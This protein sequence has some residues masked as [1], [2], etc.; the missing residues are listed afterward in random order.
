MH[1][2]RKNCKSMFSKTLGDT[3]L[4][5]RTKAMLHWGEYLNYPMS[6]VFQFVCN[7]PGGKLHLMSCPE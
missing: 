5:N 3:P 1:A 2:T 7:F 6:A 4:E